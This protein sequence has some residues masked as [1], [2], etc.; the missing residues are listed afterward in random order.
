MRRE[1]LLNAAEDRSQEI[2]RLATEQA[3]MIMRRTEEQS[4]Q[5]KIDADNYATETLRN[6]REHLMN[7]ETEIERTVLSIEK[8]LETL[9]DRPGIPGNVAG[10]EQA[11]EELDVLDTP[12]PLPLTP[13]PRRAAAPCRAP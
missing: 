10:E 13:R 3:Q 7:I 1:G 9:D 6:L 2:M 4:E 8:G 11:L 5:L 12:R